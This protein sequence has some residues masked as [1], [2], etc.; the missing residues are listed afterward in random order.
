M[1]TAGNDTSDSAPAIG[2]YVKHER[3]MPAYVQPNIYMV[4]PINVGV[5]YVLFSYYG[6]N[7]SWVYSLDFLAELLGTLLNFSHQEDIE[8]TFLSMCQNVN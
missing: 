2:R 6:T 1:R 4:W 8:Y 7:H 3:Q 5:S